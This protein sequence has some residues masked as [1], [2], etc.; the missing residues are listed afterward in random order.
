M[1]FSPK[2]AI[3]QYNPMNI[4]NLLHNCFALPIMQI[5]NLLFVRRT[6]IDWHQIVINQSITSLNH[7][8]NIALITNSDTNIRCYSPYFKHKNK[9]MLYIKK[10]NMKYWCR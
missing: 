7:P 4:F 10:Y 9:V 8:M 3:F 1:A 5:L 6:V 2:K